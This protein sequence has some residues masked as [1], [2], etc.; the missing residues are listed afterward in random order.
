MRAAR[1]KAMVEGSETAKAGTP[2]GEGSG[3]RDNE[4]RVLTPVSLAALTP[5]ARDS[6]L[7]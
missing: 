5:I 2:G 1:F 6:V 3:A 4:D 7:W